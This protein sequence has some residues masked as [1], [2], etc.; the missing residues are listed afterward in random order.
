MTLLRGQRT[1]LALCWGAGTQSVAIR[2]G[3]DIPDGLE[4][5]RWVGIRL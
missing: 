2:V 3:S 5:E 1:V 4:H